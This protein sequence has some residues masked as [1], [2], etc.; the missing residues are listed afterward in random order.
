MDREVETTTPESRGIYTPFCIPCILF[1]RNRNNTYSYVWC[2][3]QAVLPVTPCRPEY[4]DVDVSL[5]I[6][7]LSLSKY[8]SNNGLDIDAHII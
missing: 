6:C 7:S 2:C 4:R 3:P 5:S 8:H 1:I